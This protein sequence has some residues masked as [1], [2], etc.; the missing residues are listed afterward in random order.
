M[1]KSIM[2]QVAFYFY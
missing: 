2:P 1:V